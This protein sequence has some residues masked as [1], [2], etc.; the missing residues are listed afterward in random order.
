MILIL[1]KFGLNEDNYQILSEN[2]ETINRII[3]PLS[4]SMTEN[5][6]GITKEFAKQIEGLPDFPEN[7]RHINNLIFTYK[8]NERYRHENFK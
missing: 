2:G 3:I 8:Q 7:I 4:Q 6:S 1:R 5:I